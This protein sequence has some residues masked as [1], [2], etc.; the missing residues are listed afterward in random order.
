[1]SGLNAN[2]DKTSSDFKVGP[3]V[4]AALVD[5][6]IVRPFLI[7]ASTLPIAVE[8]HDVI[9]QAETGTGR[10]LGFAIPTLHGIIGPGDEG[11]N[12]LPSP[13]VPQVLVLLPTH[14][15]AK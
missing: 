15:L 14:E 7:R 3:E 1:M 9:G 13:G 8:R 12:E 2:Q 5:K 10:A 11:W 6:G 4:V